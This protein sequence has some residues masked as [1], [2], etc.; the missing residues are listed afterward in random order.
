VTADDGRV[1][2]QSTREEFGG[3]QAELASVRRR[4]KALQ[5]QAQQDRLWI[6]AGVAVLAATVLFIVY[7][8]TG[9][10]LI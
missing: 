1:S 5:W 6:G 4:L 7:E 8:R 9:L 3:V 10:L 2:L